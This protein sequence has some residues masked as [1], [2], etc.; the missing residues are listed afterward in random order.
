MRALGLLDDEGSVE[1]SSLRD[2]CRR[3]LVGGLLLYEWA[4]L[5]GADKVTQTEERSDARDTDP[6]PEVGRHLASG[7]GRLMANRLP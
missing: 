7:T 1:P 5:G 4:A 6:L 3:V 2:E